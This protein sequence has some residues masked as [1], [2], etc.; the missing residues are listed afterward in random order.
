MIEFLKKITRFLEYQERENSRLFWLIT[1][2][3]ALSSNLSFSSLPKVN[4]NLSQINVVNEINRGGGQPD[5][6]TFITT[7]KNPSGT[8]QKN[9]PEIPG[10]PQYQRQP[11]SQNLDKKVQ[12]YP[13]ISAKKLPED[14][15]NENAGNPGSPGG[16]NP[17]WNDEESNYQMPSDN[18]EFDPDWWKEYDPRF[19]QER[20]NKQSKLDNNFDEN[21]GDNSGDDS[22]TS[23]SVIEEFKDTNSLR[24]IAEASLKNPRIRKEYLELKAALA[25][26]KDP[27]TISSAKTCKIG[28]NLTLIKKGEGRY[29]IK[30]Y[31]KNE[32]KVL[33]FFN[34]G[35]NKLERQFTAAMQS[36]YGIPLRGYG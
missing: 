17:D 1:I 27:K 18:Q 26:G 14:Q 36:I 13:R 10:K 5:K 32:L 16:E 9:P 8:F 29:I 22:A 4:S 21:S 35:N 24:N 25:A 19:N 23:V 12:M 2:I 33:G 28:P 11:L 31:S 3:I 20:K 30:Q 7:S 6:P 34:R 15:N